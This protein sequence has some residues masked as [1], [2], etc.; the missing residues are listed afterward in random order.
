MVKY[1]DQLD[2]LIKSKTYQRPIENKSVFGRF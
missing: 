2:N 1:M